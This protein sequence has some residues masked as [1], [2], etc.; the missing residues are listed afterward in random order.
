L[1]FFQ[2][3]DGEPIPNDELLGATTVSSYFNSGNESTASCYHNFGFGSYNMG[4]KKLNL[5]F[6]LKQFAFR[7][8]AKLL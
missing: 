4:T 8:G 5:D 3:K 6:D 1:L 7:A 2:E